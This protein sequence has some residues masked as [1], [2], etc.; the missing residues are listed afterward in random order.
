MLEAIIASIDF[1]EYFLSKKKNINMIISRF[2]LRFYSVKDPIRPIKSSHGF[3]ID[4]L[5]VSTRLYRIA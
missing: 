3:L 5:R 4:V 1:E 2:Y